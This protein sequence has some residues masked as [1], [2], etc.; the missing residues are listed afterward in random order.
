MTLTGSAPKFVLG[1]ERTLHQAVSSELAASRQMVVHKPPGAGA[2]RSD[3][4]RH[5]GILIKFQAEPGHRVPR[6]DA[7]AASTEAVLREAGLNAAQ[8]AAAQGG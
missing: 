5:L 4:P 2:E 7:P 8:I 3:G 6:L 1:L